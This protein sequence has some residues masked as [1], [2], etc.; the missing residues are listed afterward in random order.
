MQGEDQVKFSLDTS[1]FCCLPNLFDVF[2]QIWVWVPR[3]N[4]ND[5]GNG[6]T[7]SLATV[8]I[9]G[10]M[11][12]CGTKRKNHKQTGQRWK[13][14]TTWAKRGKAP[15]NW[16]KDQQ[17]KSR[18][19]QGHANSKTKVKVMTKMIECQLFRWGM[20]IRENMSMVSSEDDGDGENCWP[21]ERLSWGLL[22]F[23]IV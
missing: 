5:A 3:A 11:P 16:T 13:A 10:K 22:G 12:E 18:Q 6:D 21:S 20:C 23:S 17:M 14:Q 9:V 1:I 8:T 15:T 7:L 4:Q 19:Q 2:Q